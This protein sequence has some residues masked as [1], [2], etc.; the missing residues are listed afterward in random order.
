[1]PLDLTEYIKSFKPPYSGETYNAK[2]TFVADPSA[3]QKTMLEVIKVQ[4]PDYI[5][6]SNA[7]VK[8]DALYNNNRGEYT[9]QPFAGKEEI[10]FE[11]FRGRYGSTAVTY[12][13]TEKGKKQGVKESSQVDFTT[14][15]LLEAVNVFLHEAYHARSQGGWRGDRS[16]AMNSSGVTEADLKK[17][18]EIARPK[19]AFDLGSLYSMKKGYLDIEEFMANAV[20]LLDMKA[21]N[22]I[23]EGTK[24]EAQLQ[25][26]E[27]I[28]QEVPAMAKFIESQRTPEIKSLRAPAEGTLGSILQSIFGGPSQVMETRGGVPPGTPR[29][30]GE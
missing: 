7:K 5:A 26:V 14:P 19:D 3:L 28:M 11:P 30:K 17:T 1:M 8:G 10:R 25:T 29:L 22:M 15:E 24:N 12:T 20:S 16:V 21:K 9:L 6:A 23:P 18:N 27:K 13:P 2:S 4:F